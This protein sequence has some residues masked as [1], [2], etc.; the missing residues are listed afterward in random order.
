MVEE[1]VKREVGVVEVE[2]VKEVE[3]EGI[4]RMV[5]L[6]VEVVFEEVGVFVVEVGL[7]VDEVCLILYFLLSFLCFVFG[8]SFWDLFLLFKNNS[9]WIL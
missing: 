2:V 7:V 4:R 5:F 6:G 1:E 9:I 3:E 8:L